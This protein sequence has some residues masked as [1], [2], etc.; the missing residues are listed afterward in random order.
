M[1]FPRDSLLIGKV[2]N[3]FV[4][5]WKGTREEQQDDLDGIFVF[6]DVGAI[7]TW[8]LDIFPGDPM[9]EFFGPGIPEMLEKQRFEKGLCLYC[10][11][12][13][14][15]YSFTFGGVRPW[16]KYCAECRRQIPDVENK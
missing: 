11:S 14:F 2:K 4:L 5:K 15:C 16:P 10:G 12:N 6:P 8:L 13:K 3:G 9:Q 1:F 7:C